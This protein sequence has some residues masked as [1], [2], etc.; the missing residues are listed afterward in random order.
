MSYTV[1]TLD[2]IAEAVDRHPA[3]VRR[4]IRN[5]GFP[6]SRSPTGTYITTHGLIDSWILAR[7]SE[8]KKQREQEATGA[9]K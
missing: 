9:G 8:D 3:T 7:A 6:A 2:K 1:E 5:Q 4:W